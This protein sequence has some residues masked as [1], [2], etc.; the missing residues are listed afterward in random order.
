MAFS[1]KVPSA[2]LATRFSPKRV[3][4]AF[5]SIATLSTLAQHPLVALLGREYAHWSF[6]I[7]RFLTGVGSAAFYP[8][9]TVLLA[10]WAPP[11]ERS[12]MMGTAYAGMNLGT[13]RKGDYEVFKI[14]N[15]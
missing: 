3:M 12:R 9:Y 11:L 13:H 7:L 5:I 1:V 10:N 14:I 8:V 4:L 15:D 6:I 2:L